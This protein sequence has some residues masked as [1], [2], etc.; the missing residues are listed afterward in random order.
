[1]AA[2]HARWLSGGFSAIA[3][4][5]MSGIASGP[6]VIPPPLFDRALY[7]H[8]QAS[9]NAGLAAELDGRIAA[10]LAERMAVINRV[11]D[12]ALLIAPRPGAFLDA[13]EAT[14]KFARIDHAWPVADDDL[15]LGNEMFD[16]LISLLDIHCVNDVPGYLAQVAAALKPDGL[17][18]FS[19]FAG[20]TLRELR[21][22][23]FAAEQEMTGGVTPRVAPMIDLRQ[24]GGLLQ[25]AGL[26]LPVADLERIP[27]RYGEVMSLMRDIKS[28]GLGN[29]LLDRKKGL[30]TS[31]L[32]L[33]AA[34]GYS[35]R[36]ADP[37]GRLPATLE[38]AWAMAWK[39]HPSQPQPLKPGSAKARLADA[40]R[41]PVSPEPGKS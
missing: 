32:L 26:S 9:A 28:L 14:G 41:P 1:M 30:T 3:S 36:F 38:L 11:F 8:R 21:E 4:S 29:C 23:L 13:L 20:E 12:R 22:A 16:C 10:D 31:G 24:A 5:T 18:V 25:R 17:A 39:P 34:A 6:A 2:D 7:L 27:L 19:F 37:D 15:R 35:A 33:R 40:L